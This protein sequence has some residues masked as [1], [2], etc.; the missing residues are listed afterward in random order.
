MTHNYEIKGMTCTGC[1]AKAKSALL[2][3][4]DVTAADVQLSSPQA[5]ISMSRHISLATLQQAL[6]AAGN[7]TITAAEEITQHE[8]L[9]SGATGSWQPYNPVFLVFGYILAVT[10]A[11]QLAAGGFHWMLWMRH[12]MA[13]FFL[14]FSFFKLL[15]VQ[16]FADSYATYD[17]I[18]KRW[19]PWGYVYVAMEVLLGFAFLVNFNPLV[20][21]ILTVTI[22]GVSIVGVLQ[23]VLNKRKIRCACLGAV[24]NLPMSTVTIVEDG[25][26]IIMSAIMVV[27]Q[28]A[29]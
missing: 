2:K 10:L 18:S 29:G 15:D 8:Q 11:V 3:L 1:V 19:R 22:M 26:M 23:S 21:N 13:G 17:I 25:V 7:Y 12:F 16:G 14:T 20:T 24:F 27:I 4:P 6:H 5:T 9:T 28:I